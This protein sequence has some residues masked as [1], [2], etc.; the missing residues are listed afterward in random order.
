MS[1]MRGQYYVWSSANSVHI[2]IAQSDDSFGSIWAANFK[3]KTGVSMP[4][5]IFDELVAMRWAEMTKSQKKQAIKR[6]IKKWSDNGGCDITKLKKLLTI[7][8]K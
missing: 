7:K 5:K 6:S 4:H 1:Y 3:E 2:W 8:K